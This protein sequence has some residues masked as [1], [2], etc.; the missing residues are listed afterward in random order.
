MRSVVLVES[1][2]MQMSL[3]EK[4]MASAFAFSDLIGVILAPLDKKW[5]VQLAA[6]AQWLTRASRHERATIP[7]NR[8]TTT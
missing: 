4:P 7:A 3:I 6:R 2:M 1:S 8:I 5:P